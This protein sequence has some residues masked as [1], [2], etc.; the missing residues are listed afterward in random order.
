M[1]A[2]AGAVLAAVL[3]LPV[4]AQDA[5]SLTPAPPPLLIPDPGLVDWRIVNRFSPFQALP[6]PAG[7]FERFA[8]RPGE[9]AEDWHARLWARDGAAFE[10]P[11]AAAL[12]TGGQT[13]WDAQAELPTAPVLGW[14]RGE[15][16]P[17]ARINITLRYP[18]DGPCRWEAG[19]TR[20]LAPNCADPTAVSVPQS[21]LPVSL[22]LGASPAAVTVLVRPRH[23][24]ILGLGDSYASGEGNPDRPT[25]WEAWFAPP[26]GDTR[27][28]VRDQGIRDEALW[29]DDRCNRSFFSYQSLAAL[30]RASDDPHRLVSFVHLACSG[31]EIFNGILAAQNA[32]AGSQ[33]LNRFSQL[34][35]ALHAL[36]QVPL[37][38]D[39]GPVDPRWLQ[40]A[41]LDAFARR[42][43]ALLRPLDGFDVSTRERR[44]ETGRDEPRSGMLTCPDGA[45][46]PP[47]LIL[48]SIGGND[49]GF[50]DLVRYFLVPMTVDFGL[51]NGLVLPDMCLDP[52]Y[53]YGDP[54]LAI[55]AH[56]A[57]R[58]AANGYHSGT[59]IGA[60][61]D[62][63]GIQ[64][65]YALLVSL[66]KG[67]L[68]VSANQIA[69]VQYPDPLRQGIRVPPTQAEWAG[70]VA[71]LELEAEA[72]LGPVAEATAP[73]RQVPE[74]T[75]A[76]LL[77]QPHLVPGSAPG[78]DPL[79]PWTALSARDPLEITANWAFN[80]RPVEAVNL[81]RQI[82]DLR[83]ALTNV[84]LDE[85]LRFACAGRDAFVGRGWNTG[86]RLNLPSHGTGVDRWPVSDW[87][88]YAFDPDGRAIRTANDSYLTQQDIYGTVHP[89]LAG[90][91]LLAD[92]LIA[93][94]A[95]P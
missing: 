3:A 38:V 7:S 2:W 47:D 35:A 21:G 22:R 76:R 37:G 82:E 31:A 44:D 80:L 32:P 62:P 94:L 50:G 66:L 13:P 39:Y 60:P 58:D 72:T 28:L 92:I 86:T 46:R 59:L 41:A 9:S 75:C 55:T 54:D 27:W 8:F 29:L 70:A 25:R 52:R 71:A 87:Q 30:R 5:P 63:A 18:F 56:C 79:S 95:Q 88:P 20:I 90:H 57:A 85:G 73:E 43:G 6:D 78:L 74:P 11:Y 15:A 33:G 34:N 91:T 45:L 4:G 26:A 61:G 77:I 53:R 12:A 48:L 24:V 64:A 19:E 42:N 40:G 81:L 65:R 10:S 67:Y 23:E 84:A 1:R 89:N 14:I 49:I 17:S 68:K 69:A 36:C 93:R 51:L 16:D 83:R